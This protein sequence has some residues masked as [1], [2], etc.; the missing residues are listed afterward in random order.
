MVDLTTQYLGFKLKNPLVASASPI[1]KKLSGMRKL[2]DAGVSAIVMY[3]LF[4]EQI[5]YESKSLDHFLNV[6]TETFAEAVTYFPEMPQYNI[7]HPERLKRIDAALQNHP[8]LALAGNGYRG[9]GIPD[10]I[11]SGE[12]AVKKILE[13]RRAENSLSPALTTL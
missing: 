11:H 2:E 1:S 8:E 9:I 7:G 6:G 3:S 4:E 12:L 13:N 5:E 10:C